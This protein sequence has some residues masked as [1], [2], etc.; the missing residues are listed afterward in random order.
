MSCTALLS[1]LF[2]VDTDSDA[3]IIRKGW[4]ANKGTSPTIKIANGGTK[5]TENGAEWNKAS[6]LRQLHKNST[7]LSPPS[8]GKEHRPFGADVECEV[9]ESTSRRLAQLSVSADLY[10]SLPPASP[11]PS[12]SPYPSKAGPDI[13]IGA[14]DQLLHGDAGVLDVVMSYEDAESVDV[15]MSAPV[16][17]PVGS[18]AESSR[19]PLSASIN[20]DLST[21]IPDYQGSIA[22]AKM[23]KAVVDKSK[24][25]ARV[26]RS[27]TSALSGL[28]LVPDV[29]SN[30]TASGTSFSNS[31]ALGIIGGFDTSAPDQLED[32][33][34][35]L[36]RFKNSTPK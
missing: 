31:I 3:S 11:A 29:I 27:T 17:S 34:S 23:L 28:L 13:L 33:V 21:V 8:R 24:C 2:G 1:T 7:T 36:F 10:S 4:T 12:P 35:K 22:L 32:G 16:T 19:S 30:A 6:V 9:S 14:S 18:I 26:K 25:S 20:D 5:I 15:I